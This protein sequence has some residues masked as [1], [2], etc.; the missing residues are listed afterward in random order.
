MKKIITLVCLITI[1]YAAIAQIRTINGTPSTVLTS[2]AFLDASSSATYDATTN[3]AKGI[4]FPRVDLTTFT[5]L[6]LTGGGSSFRNRYDG[7]I[8]YNTATSGVALAGATSGTLSRGFWYYNNSAAGVGAGTITGGTWTP[9]GSTSVKNISSTE[10]ATSTSIGGK[11]VYALS[12]TFTASGNKA[13]VSITVP[14]GMTG[15]YKMTTYVT[16]LNLIKKTFRNEISS[17]D[18][19]PLVLNTD[20]VVT[21][22]GLFSEVYPAG[23]YAYT[24][25]YF[26]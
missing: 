13:L 10:I 6:G 7:F 24:L 23:D 21:G 5:F 3:S 18:I 2:S 12:G 16:D 22:N 4:A 15:Y 25:E 1:N 11:Q 17:F 20:N 14:T 19:N 9:V 8:V 26:K